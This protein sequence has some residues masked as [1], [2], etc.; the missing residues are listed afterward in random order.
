MTVS[1]LSNKLAKLIEENAGQILQKWTRNVLA[2]KTTS[3]FTREN[4]IE[5]E[6]KA[7]LVLGELEKWINYGADPEEIGRIYAKEGMKFF[8]MQ[9]PLCEVLRALV[10]L[11]ATVL[12]YATSE[13]MSET[14]YEMQQLS[15]LTGRMMTFF[16]R[17]QYYISRG[18]TEEMNRKIKELWHLTDEDTDKI[19]F[20]KS[21]YKR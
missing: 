9:I 3:T 1:L 21:F 11:R 14:G 5:I 10:L 19:F 15:E 18:Y 7:R 8:K 2:D 16:D 4:L 6:K 20:E 12:K 17:I 13:V